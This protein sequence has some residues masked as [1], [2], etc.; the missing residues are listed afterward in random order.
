MADQ[1]I[2]LKE[3]LLARSGCREKG[4]FLGVSRLL[5]EEVSVILAPE[6]PT[7]W[8][9]CRGCLWLEFLHLSVL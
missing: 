7:V 4:R 9:L 3:Q 1:L 5:K 2:L 6:L 8:P